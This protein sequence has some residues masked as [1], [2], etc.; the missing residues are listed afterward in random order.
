ML[1]ARSGNQRGHIRGQALFDRLLQGQAEGFLQGRQ[2]RQHEQ[3]RQHRAASIRRTRS[4]RIIG[5]AR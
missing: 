2:Q 1:D 3:Q 4:E 5:S